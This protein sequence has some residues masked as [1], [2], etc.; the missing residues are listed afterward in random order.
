MV[1]VVVVAVVF[2]NSETLFQALQ[3]TKNT[4]IAKLLT[5]LPSPS[6]NKNKKNW[7][8]KQKEKKEKEKKLRKT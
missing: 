6:P 3:S 1:I 8:I 7:L 5:I 4:K 2:C